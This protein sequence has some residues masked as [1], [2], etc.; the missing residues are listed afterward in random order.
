MYKKDKVF[1]CKAENGFSILEIAIVLVIAGLLLTMLLPTYKIYQNS[2]DYNK[3][4]E[5]MEMVQ[6]TLR[7]YYGLNGHYPCPANPNSSTGSANY[8]REQ[9]RS[10]I[11]DPCP[12]GL[13]CVTS[14]SRDADGDGNP[15]PVV[16]GTLPFRTLADNASDINKFREFHGIDGYDMKITYAVSELMTNHANTVS[17]P[18]NPQLGAVNVKDENNVDILAI[19]SSAHYVIVSH[20]QDRVGAYSRNGN[21]MGGCTI[22]DIHGNVAPVPLGNNIGASGV[23]VQLENCDEN[24]AIFVNSLRYLADT[25][26]YFDDIVFFNTN[27]SSSLWRISNASTATNTL[28]YNTNFGYVGV[29][30]NNPVA[31]LDVDGDVKADESLVADNGFCMLSDTDCL[32]PENLGGTGMTPCPPGEAATGIEG[33]ELVCA[34]LFTS[35][36][37]FTCPNPGEFVTSFTN[38]GNVTCAVP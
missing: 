37:D 14:G 29:G 9:C 25:D 8:G 6:E 16:I 31:K 18:I 4:I 17:N 12:A 7:E 28:I 15:D 2:K 32:F 30:V 22:L 19:P 13:K 21:S 3:T 27:A 20:G 36:I 24:D 5:H 26:A 33:N 34:P 1:C 11:T 35:I 23:K 10:N 38:T